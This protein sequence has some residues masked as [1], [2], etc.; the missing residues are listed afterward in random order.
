MVGRPIA[1]VLLSIFLALDMP[2]SARGAEPQNVL[3]ICVDDLKPALGCYGD[4]LANT[5]NIDQLASRSVV[6]QRAYCNQAVCSPSRNALLSGLRPTTLGIY[7]LATHLRDAN[8][9]LITMPQWFK[10]QGYRTESLGKIFHVGH[11]NRD[12]ELSWSVPSW[13]AKVVQYALPENRPP[14]TPM[15]REEARFS[16]QDPK[17]K[18]KG[19]P[20]EVAD[21]PDETYADGAVANQ[22]IVRLRRASEDPKTPFFLAVGFVKPHLPFVAP[23]RYWDLFEPNKFPLASYQSAPAG[24]P[25]VAMHGFGELR[26][27][28]GISEKEPVQETMQQHLLHGYYAATSYVDAQIGKVLDELRRLGLDQNTIVIL[29]GDHGWH[30]GDH[31]LWCKHSNF[32][33]A[34]RIP[35]LISA[36]GLPSHRSNGLVES[37]DLFPTLCDLANLPLPSNPLDGISLA[38]HLSDSRVPTKQH[39]LHV[40]PRGRG[41]DGEILGRAVRTERYRLVE[42]KPYTGDGKVELELYDYLDDPL[43]TSNLAEE[44]PEVVAELLKQMETYGDPRPPISA[45]R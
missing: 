11:G 18:P 22:A 19:P 28:R 9:D 30:L 41:K 8:P 10:Q 43:E 26:Q 17:G 1:L 44:L 36:P 40:Y 27:Y 13:K 25:Q 5:P 34:A 2:V 35:L 45:K 38:T 4:P 23:K 7:D 6:F 31:G 24:A 12:D 37:V 33:Q 39:I 42:W 32:E 15:T 29:W 16:N 20:T 3:L 21:V 14:K